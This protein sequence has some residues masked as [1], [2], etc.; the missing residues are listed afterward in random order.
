VPDLLVLC[1]HAVSDDWDA[2]LSVTPEDL[3]RQVG[4][5][6][7]RG[8]RGATFTQ[9]V[10]APP[11]RRTLAVTFDDGYRS[12]KELAEPILTRL[13]VPATLFVPTDWIGREEPMAWPG[14]DEWIGS[15]WEDELR[16]MNWDEARELE[17]SGWEIGAHTCSHP[18]LTTCDDEALRRELVDSKRIC[19]ERLG[20]PCP[21]IAYPYGDVD[22]RV[23][24]AAHDAGY[25]AAAALPTR[26]HAPLPLSW[27]RVGVYRHDSLPRF[28]R[29]VSR[30]MRWL[31]VSPVWPAAQGAMQAA[32]GRSAGAKKS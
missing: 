12:V 1:Y 7:E 22:A 29:Q 16:P 20:S 5:L 6:V 19:E 23:M 10:T 3:E 8:Y 13:G 17:A 21:S 15:E 25:S 14:I 24:A 9:A 28:R 32:R 2:G 30:G 26:F 4:M 18:H 31:Q 27:P 11:A